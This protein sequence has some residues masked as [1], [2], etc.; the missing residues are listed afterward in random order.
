MTIETATL[1]GGC[2][3]CVEAGF[4]RLDG[5]Q[6]VVAGYAGGEIDKPTYEQVC[7]G[8]TGHAEVIQVSYDSDIIDY[9]TLL[10]VF[11]ALHDPTTLNRQGNDVGSQYRSIILYHNDTQKQQAQAMIE[12]L[13]SE[14]IWNDPIVTEIKALDVFYPAETYHQN[15]YQLNPDNRYC[16]AVI[17][18]KLEK[19]KKRFAKLLK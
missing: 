14:K 13:S 12:E 11:F 10:T 1:G 16:N 19:L 17:P 6:S 4:L 7:N 8:T 15:F 5:V 18:P 3:W 2:F 9:K